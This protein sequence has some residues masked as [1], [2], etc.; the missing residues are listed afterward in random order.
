MEMTLGAEAELYLWVI[1]AHVADKPRYLCYI[2]IH[3]AETV[4]RKNLVIMKG[5][6]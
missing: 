4:S 6:K 2:F 1:A 3:G 5:T